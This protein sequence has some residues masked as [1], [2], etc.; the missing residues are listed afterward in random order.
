MGEIKEIFLDLRKFIFRR[1]KYWLLPL[2]A[3]FILFGVLTFLSHPLA[4]APLLYSIF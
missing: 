2:I 4:V 1:G 3:L